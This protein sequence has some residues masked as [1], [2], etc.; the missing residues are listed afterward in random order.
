[1][2]L[3]TQIKLEGMQTQDDLLALQL[4]MLLDMRDHI[5][6]HVQRVKAEREQLDKQKLALLTN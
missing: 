3:I 5:T 6:E 1:M 2:E 4:D